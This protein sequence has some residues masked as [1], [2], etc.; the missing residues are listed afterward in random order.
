MDIFCDI[1]LDLQNQPSEELNEALRELLS[2]VQSSI[3][4]SRN[5]FY[6]SLGYAVAM[7]ML[8]GLQLIPA[9]FFGAAGAVT[10]CYLYKV[11][12][13]FR[14]RYCDKD[15]RIVLIYKIVLFH[16][17]EESCLRKESYQI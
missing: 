15:V 3:R 7:L 10:I 1:Y 14:N 5:F 16:L 13:F 9:V 11:I 6:I 17:L 8:L 12:E 4:I 2:S